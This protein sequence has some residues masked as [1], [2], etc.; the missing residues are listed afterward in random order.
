MMMRKIAIVAATCT[1]ML[2]GI[3]STAALANELV[4]VKVAAL[5]SIAASPI[6][7]A[8]EK[9]Y[10]EE[11]GLDV[12][13]VNFQNTATMV[14]P[15]SAGQIDVAAGAPTLGFY[16]AKL[17]GLK[18]KLV[19]DLGRN[20]A[21][22]GFNALVVRKDLYDSGKVKSVKD[23]KGLTVGSVS[24]NSPMD[25]EL[26]LG[27]KQ[28]GMTLDDVELKV[29]SFPNMLAA[30]AS[31]NLDAAMLVEPFV[32]IAAKQGAGVRIAGADEMSPDF[33]VS[34]V[35][36]GE[37]FMNDKPEAAAKYL[38]AYVRG[39]RFYLDAIQT[40]EGKDELFAIVGEYARLKDR[41]I[42]D[43]I[44]FP[45]FDRDGYF[46][47]DT[48]NLTMDWFADKGMLKEKP[49]MKDMVDFSYLNAAL[50]KIGRTGP[51]IDVE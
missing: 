5:R 51:R 2:S 27:L 16:N 49:A 28:V 48:I 41:A 11:A 13:I 23:L 45:G 17:N 7:I 22:H 21:G 20:S 9:G 50:D 36:Y 40:K 4:P 19:A 44:A 37:T 12:E 42:L 33:N 26:D 39:V 15:L 35:I 32:A 31:Q 34:G 38:E 3:M 46:N 43:T 47:I 29:L 18:M 1:A 24:P 14:A 25:I 10:F 6:V 8:K 30:L